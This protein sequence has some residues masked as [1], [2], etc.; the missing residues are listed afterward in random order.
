MKR[1]IVGMDLAKNVVQVR[2]VDEH[3]KAM[4]RKKRF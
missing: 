4:V 2:R 3:G 1:T